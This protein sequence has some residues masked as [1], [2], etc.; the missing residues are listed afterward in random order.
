MAYLTPDTPRRRIVTAGAVVAVHGA[1]ALAI[2]TGF[3]GGLI[4]IIEDEHFPASTYVEPPKPM[5]SVAPTA[6][7]VESRQ[8]STPQSDI[9]QPRETFHD[10][11]IIFDPG[12]FSPGSFGHDTGP[13]NVPLEPSPSPGPSFTPR[14]ARPL[15]DPSRWASERDYPGNALRRGDQGITRFEITVGVDGRVRDCT[16]TRTSGSAE[17]DAATCAKVSERARFTPARDTHGDLVVGRYAN[18]IRWQIPE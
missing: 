14:A 9:L 17:L 1:M 3:A 8:T 6:E 16:V 11:E 2:M 12:P 5:P 7:P 13:L 10:P 4:A 15:T 18:A